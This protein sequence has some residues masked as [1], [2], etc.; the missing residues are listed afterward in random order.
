MNSSNYEIFRDILSGIIVAKSNER[1]R[2]SSKRKANKARRNNTSSSNN[3]VK[4]TPVVKTEPFQRANPEDLAEFVD[5]FYHFS[6]LYWRQIL[7]QCSSSRLKSSPTS[8]TSSNPSP[9]ALPSKTLP[10]EQMSTQP[11][12]QL[13]SLKLSRQL[14]HQQ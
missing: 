10:S 6:L 9:T 13:P 3:H 5:V 11:P 12:F 2:E 8:P 1:P 14:S 7:K 4:T